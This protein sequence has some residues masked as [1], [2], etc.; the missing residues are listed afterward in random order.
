MTRSCAGRSGT[1]PTATDQRGL[2]S[3][4]LLIAPAKIAHQGWNDLE[5]AAAATPRA[6]PADRDPGATS[7]SR[8]NL[9]RIAFDVFGSDTARESVSAPAISAIADQASASGFL[10]PSF[11]RSFARAATNLLMTYLKPYVEGSYMRRDD[12]ALCP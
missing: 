3:A 12:D 6:A 2:S 1:R 10:A 7:P 11:F 8:E 4:T 5:S 9:R